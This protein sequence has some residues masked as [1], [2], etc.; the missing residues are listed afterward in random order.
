MNNDKNYVQTYGLSFLE[1][2]GPKPEILI[3]LFDQMGFTK[4]GEHPDKPIS[5]YSQ[6]NIH[7]I[8]NPEIGGNAEIFREKHIRGV[9]SFGIQVDNSKEAFSQAVA[10]GATPAVTTDYDIPAICGVGASLIYLVDEEHENNLF[11]TFGL[12]EIVGNFPGVGLIDIDHLTH[13]LEIGGIK[14]WVNFYET[15]FGFKS[16]TSF[17]IEGEKTGLL[18][19]VVVSP[20]ERIK[21]PLNESK[22]DKS[23]IAEF[24]HEYNGEGIQHI[25]LTCGNIYESVVQLRENG[26][27]FQD[28]PDTY[29]ELI[30]KRLPENQEPISRLQEQRI[31]VDGGD[32]NGGGTLLQIF[33]KES[34]G[35]VFFEYIQRKENDGFGKGNF[36][37][38]F[39]SIELDQK[40]RGVI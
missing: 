27:V 1:F 5:V 8:S 37:A 16:V 38:L 15:V 34:I 22:D 18:S 29:Y 2:S 32:E 17:D 31:L 30:P 4:S 40:R 19:E 10:L 24:V 13:N 12:K 26:I 33:A 20:N 36:Q 6:G 7:F 39:E 14:E 21:I 9:C 23:Q 28:T 3:S 25:A 11:K 35:P